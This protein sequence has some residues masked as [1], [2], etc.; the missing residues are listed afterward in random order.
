MPEL[1][2]TRRQMLAGPALALARQPVLALDE[3]RR[4]ALAYCESIRDSGA[5]YG[6]YRGG[7]G[8]RTDLYAAC[9]VAILRA[10]MGEDLVR[11]FPPEHRLQW[12]DHINSYVDRSIKP[13]DGSYTDTFG[14]SKLHANGMVV[15]ALG[16][17]GGRQ[18]WPVRLYDP[19]RTPE[20]VAAWLERIDWSRQWAASHEFW[21]GMICFSYSR[22]CP[23]KW[24]EAVFNWLDE[25]LD[26]RTG[27]WRKNVPHTG[28]HEPLGGSVHILPLYE[29]HGRRFPYA[30]RLIDSV[31]DLQLANGRW[32]QTKNPLVM[33]YLELDAL[34]ALNL[35]QTYVPGY[36][37]RQIR[38]AAERY[39]RL[40]C[41]YYRTQRQEL[42]K[43]HPHLVLGAMGTF[44][45]LSR[46]CPEMFPSDGEWTDIFS[47]PRFHNTAAVEAE[48]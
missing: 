6:C 44:G 28:R 33:D 7:P 8:R 19:F 34:Y 46:M 32:L 21:G 37:G 11:T 38:A 36:R 41:E 31:L 10:V 40:V 35:M 3:V 18:K 5:P 45:L 13:P 24:L 17:L 27:W 47:D 48:S 30:E 4:D 15:G 14:H 12:I 20:K 29:H 39:G 22:S 9:D 26:E 1:A 2:L 25:N 16:A 42:Y 43:L 23:P